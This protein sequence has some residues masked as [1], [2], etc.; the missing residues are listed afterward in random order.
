[1]NE[2]LLRDR[3]DLLRHDVTLV[4]SALLEPFFRYRQGHDYI[5]LLSHAQDPFLE[6]SHKKAPD[7]FATLEFESKERLT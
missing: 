1:M 3:R 6:Q 4:K 2:G 7:I 5:E